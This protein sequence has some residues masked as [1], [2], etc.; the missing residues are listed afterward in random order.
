MQKTF[1][2]RELQFLDS[3]LRSVS[4]PAQVGRQPVTMDYRQDR[5]T[6]ETRL[7]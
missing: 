7:Y 4:Y 2:G 5:V 6:I 1:F 3:G